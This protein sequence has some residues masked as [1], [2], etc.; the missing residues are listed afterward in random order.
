MYSLLCRNSSE[1]KC[2]LFLNSEHFESNDNEAPSLNTEKISQ[3]VNNK[4]PNDT[5][6]TIPFITPEQVTNYINKLDCSKATGLDGIGPRILKIAA[7]AFSPSIAKLIN[8]SIATGRF[9]SQ[10]TQAKVLPIF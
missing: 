2:I 8:K 10:L 5:F 6:F 3:Y 1:I 7:C 9:P 4:I